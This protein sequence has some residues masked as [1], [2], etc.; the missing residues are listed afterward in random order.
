M[1]APNPG[2]QSPPPSQQT[3]RQTGAPGSGKAGAAPSD[4]HAKEE[5]EKVKSDESSVL[6]SNPEGPME[7]PAHEKVAKD[8]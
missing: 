2:R 6:S 7:G 3:S 4:E 8:V 1:S 5:S